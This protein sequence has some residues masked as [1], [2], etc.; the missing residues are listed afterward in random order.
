MNRKLI[1]FIERK[2]KYFKKMNGNVFFIVKEK[3]IFSYI[4]LSIQKIK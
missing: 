4:V 3:V 1:T 2:V